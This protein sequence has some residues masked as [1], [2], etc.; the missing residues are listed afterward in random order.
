MSSFM[1]MSLHRTTGASVTGW[2]SLGDS[3][4]CT[5]TVTDEDGVQLSVVLFS[6]TPFD[7]QRDAH[8]ASQE[9]THE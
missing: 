2:R 1:F 4:S 9:I 5:L 8:G 6:K 3:Y 7:I